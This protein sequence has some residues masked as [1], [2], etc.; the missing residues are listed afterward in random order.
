MED[1]LYHYGVLGMKWGRR[2]QRAKSGSSKTGKVSN[3]K[4]NV[5]KKLANVDKEKVKKIAKTSAV[6]AGAAALAIAAPHVA[7]FTMSQVNSFNRNNIYREWLYNHDMVANKGFDY[8]G[9]N[10]Y[11]RTTGGGNSR[12]GSFVSEIIKGKKK[13]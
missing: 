5:Q 10:T 9:N 6:I 13:F 11:M 1:E 3:I 2:K 12:S 8:L 4:K 7:S